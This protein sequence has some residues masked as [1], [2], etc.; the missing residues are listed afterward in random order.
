MRRSRR[1]SERKERAA[2][3]AENKA[4][5][6]TPDVKPAKKAAPKKAESG[7]TVS[8][9][10]LATGDYATVSGTDQYGSPIHG[11]G[12]VHGATAV[13]VGKRGSKVKREAVQVSLTETK[14]GADGWRMAVLLDADDKA[15]VH[16]APLDAAD[17]PPPPRKAPA[18]KAAPKAEPEQPGRLSADPAVREVQV[19]N[20]IREAYRELRPGAGINGFVSLANIRDA[21]GEE[22]NRREVDR[23]LI[24]MATREP[25]PGRPDNARLVPVEFGRSQRDRDAALSMGGGQVHALSIDDP[26]PRPLPAPEP[27]KP[28]AKKAPAK[29]A[30]PAKSPTVEPLTGGHTATTELLTHP[31]GTKTVRKTLSQDLRGDNGQIDA[32]ELA[33]HVMAAVGISAPKVV[34]RSS[35]SIELTHIEGQ[36]G[37]TFTGPTAR[38]ARRHSRQRR[39][40]PHGSRQRPDGIGRPPEPW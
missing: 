27:A 14:S 11:T 29:K 8:A 10:D 12:Y 25:R 3:R 19:E 20:R 26:S 24:G 9:G 38:R 4:P 37:Y 36:S 18:K 30:A 6:T 5:A 7:R 34:R 21:L 2:K 16:A 35:R 23:V 33:S 28:A 15:E 39:R 31:D 40:P 1:P 32:E 17:A 22:F 13:R